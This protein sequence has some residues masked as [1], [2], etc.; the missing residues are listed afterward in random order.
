MIYDL[1]GWY[2]EGL[3]RLEALTRVAE[4][5]QKGQ[6]ENALGL[7]YAFQ[8]WLQ[9]RRGHLA[10]ARQRFEQGIRILRASGE[11]LALAEAL[12]MYGPVLTRP[13]RSRKKPS[14]RPVPRM[15]PGILPMH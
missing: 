4:Q 10:Q 15:I 7:A 11:G 2:K 12:T 14:P 6:Y 13:S 3:E 1:R 9:F 5:D 8:G